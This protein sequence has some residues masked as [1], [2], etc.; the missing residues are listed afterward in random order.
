MESHCV[1]ANFA[2]SPDCELSGG[3]FVPADAAATRLFHLHQGCKCPGCICWIRERSPRP[4]VCVNRVSPSLLYAVSI[5]R[6]E[7]R[8]FSGERVEISALLD[9][10]DIGR[11]G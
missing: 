5:T 4:T 2:G 9:N 6:D 8:R 1:P 10:C 7:L 3:I 11:K